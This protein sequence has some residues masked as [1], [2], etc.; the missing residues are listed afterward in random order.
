M[1]QVQKNSNRIFILMVGILFLFNCRINAQ[2]SAVQDATGEA[3]YKVFGSA[4][5]INTSDENISFSHD[6]LKRSNSKRFKRFGIMAKITPNEGI[7]N[8]RN[9]DG[10]L[11]DGE[12]GVYRG[13]KTTSSHRALTGWS[14]EIYASINGS[15][16]RNKFYNINNS[17]DDLIYSKGYAGFKIELGSFGYYGDVLWGLSINAGN[18]TNVED[19]DQKTISQLVMAS[20]L[21]SLRIT[22]NEAAYDIN[23]F[24]QNLTFVNINAD[25]F[26]PLST[27]STL[28]NL[29]LGLHLRA[30]AMQ[31]F[32]FKLNPAIGL[33]I[34]KVG[35]PQSIVIGLNLQMMDMFNADKSDDSS[36][37]R[38]VINLTA[39]FK[40]N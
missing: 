9:D 31:D 20:N 34:S 40:L 11:I 2:T 8:L 29:Y 27:D 33:Y 1:K 7:A 26:Y 14:R 4:I 28:G 37:N 18:K 24:K 25:G 19:I 17:P 13:W 3:A 32:K 5:T 16:D 36:I 38:M 23:E 21:D 22:N 6:I 30:K 35:A 39:G 15:V 10:F 12:L